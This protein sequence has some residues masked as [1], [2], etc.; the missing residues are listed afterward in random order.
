VT[1]KDDTA[2]KPK[3]ATVKLNYLA[4]FSRNRKSF[5]LGAIDL[6]AMNQLVVRCDL[7]GGLPI[8]ISTLADVTRSG[9]S[10]IRRSLARLAEAGFITVKH[11]TGRSSIIRVIYEKAKPKWVKR[12]AERRANRQGD[13]TDPAN[14]LADT[15][16]KLQRTP[17]QDLSAI[18]IP[19][20]HKSSH[21]SK[22]PKGRVFEDAFAQGEKEEIDHVFQP[23]IT[24]LPDGPGDSDEPD[25]DMDRAPRQPGLERMEPADD[26]Y[27]AAFQNFKKIWPKKDAHEGKLLGA[28]KNHVAKPGIDPAVVLAAARRWKQHAHGNPYAW[29]PYGG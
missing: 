19:S 8:R 10:S 25:D 15:P 16:P 28:W 17:R 4:W 23:D 12:E 21:I 2:G 11:R 18:S 6:M 22:R 1:T 29:I 13:T 14:A 5:K 9:T 26:D 24:T 3:P 27:D 20:D 7:T